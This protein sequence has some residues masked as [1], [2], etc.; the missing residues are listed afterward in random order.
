MKNR[1]DINPKKVVPQ[2]DST[3]I[4]GD[5]LNYNHYYSGYHEQQLIYQHLLKLVQ[6]ESLDQ[7]LARFR[8]LFIERANYPEPEIL[9]ILDKITAQKIKE[10]NEKK[11]LSYSHQL[12][13][14]EPPTT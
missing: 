12:L 11:V 6:K 13:A 10:E 7:M 5:K 9:P 1:I 8:S 4:I 14:H 3:K 2:A